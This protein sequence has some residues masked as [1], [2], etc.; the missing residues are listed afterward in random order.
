MLAPVGEGFGTASAVARAVTPTA[1]V[2][3]RDQFT[4]TTAGNALNARVAPV[5]GTWATSGDATDYAFSDDL[6]GENVKRSAGSGTNGRFA[7]LGATVPTD[8][9][10][11][12]LVYHDAGSAALALNSACQFGVIAR[13]VDSS[14]YLRA[15]LYFDKDTFGLTTTQFAVVRVVAGVSSGMGFKYLVPGGSTEDT[16]YAIRL[17]AY[18]NG[19][20]VAQLLNSD[21]TSVLAT[22]D[23]SHSD[24]AT[25]GTLDNGGFGLYDRN[26]STTGT[27]N[28]YFDDFA[29]YIPTPPDAAIFASQSLEIRHDA[30]ERENSTGTG[31][32]RVTPTAAAICGCG[33]RGRRAAARGSS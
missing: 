14:N 33:R 9:Q 29:V 17:V 12:A 24:L 10:V 16:W 6:S 26:T 7:I 20:V 13:W 3:G 28:R 27:I 11:E 2:S 4:S 19:R 32:G 30:A 22:L 25:G 1:A 18:A 8:T 23:S 21:K 5:G 15:V 31:W